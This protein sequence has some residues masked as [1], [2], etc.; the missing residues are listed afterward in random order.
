MENI[1]ILFVDDEINILHSLKRVFRKEQYQ[2]HTAVS[3][4]EGIRILNE[5]PMKVVVSDMRMPGK[6]GVEFLR[7]VKQLYPDTVRIILSGYSDIDVIQSAINEGEVYRYITKPWDDEELKN[8]IKRSVEQYELMLEN[9]Q[10]QNTIIMQNQELKQW[11]KILEQKIE[12]RTRELKL[13]NEILTLS[14]EVLSKVSIAI[15]CVDPQGTIVQINN[16]CSEIFSN[17]NGKLFGCSLSNVFSKKLSGILEN[18]LL[19]KTKFSMADVQ[20]LN[21]NYSLVFHPLFVHGEFRGG[22]IEIYHVNSEK[23]LS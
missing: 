14:Q 3:A 11:N 21:G 7:E 4:E 20:I 17:L 10:L 22:I 15:M 16:K 18:N 13:R 5:I 23:L 2:I 6:T 12:D 1:P 19:D 8:N 9:R